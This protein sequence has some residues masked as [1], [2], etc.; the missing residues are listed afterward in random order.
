[1]TADEAKKRIADIEAA[2]AQA[3][4]WNDKEKAQG[5]IREM[6]EIQAT[7]AGPVR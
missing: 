4:F 2:M 7:A 3:D 5:M 6:K 1:M